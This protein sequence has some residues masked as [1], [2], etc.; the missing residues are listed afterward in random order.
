M[1]STAGYEHAAIALSKV[2]KAASEAERQQN[3][4]RTNTYAGCVPMIGNV[5][6]KIAIAKHKKQQ[7][8]RSTNILSTEQRKTKL[9]TDQ[10]K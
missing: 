6:I 2:R 9:T 3:K 8:K 1:K 5:Q 10:Q 7:A 4:H